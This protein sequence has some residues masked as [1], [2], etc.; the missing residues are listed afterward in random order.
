MPA[1]CAM[2]AGGWAAG[3]SG[4][5]RFYHKSGSAGGDK[6][7]VPM[8]LKWRQWPTMQGE[9]TVHALICMARTW[10]I[11]ILRFDVLA[12]LSAKSKAMMII[13]EMG[14]TMTTSKWQTMIGPTHAVWVGSW[15]LSVYYCFCILVFWLLQRRLPP[16][17]KDR[18]SGLTEMLSFVLFVCV[19]CYRLVT[20]SGVHSPTVFSMMTINKIQWY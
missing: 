20:S 19:P 12:L 8:A 3:N 17:S 1:Y 9:W 5:S 18:Q 16:I 13:T 2:L 11:Y 4:G 10:N 6:A 7:A 14:I 15:W